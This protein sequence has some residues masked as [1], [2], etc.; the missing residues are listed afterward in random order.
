MSIFDEW[1]KIEGTQ[2]EKDIEEYRWM[3]YQAGGRVQTDPETGLPNPYGPDAKD[4]RERY[5][6]MQ[7][8]LRAQDDAIEFDG[9]GDW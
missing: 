4:V 6:A 9:M 8:R 1:R 2:L 3:C 5:E 7:E